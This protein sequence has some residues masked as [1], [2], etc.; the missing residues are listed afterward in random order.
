MTDSIMDPAAWVGLTS[1]AE[2]R[3]DRH[4][5]ADFDVLMGRSPGPVA[6][7]GFHWTLFGRL[8]A[9]LRR[10][11]HPR[12]MEPLPPLAF[13]RRMWAGSVIAWHLTLSAGHTA[14]R[15]TR[16]SRAAMKTGRGGPML[17]I[18]LEHDLEIEGHGLAIEERQDIAFLEGKASVPDGPAEPLPFAADW[19]APLRFDEV[20][21]FAYSALTCNMHRIHYDHPY[22]T[23]AEGFPGLV[24]HGPLLAT[25]LMHAAESHAPCAG[26]LRRFEVRARR[27]VF[28]AR[29]LMMMG[30][31]TDVPGELQ[32][33]LLDEGGRIAMTA[34]AKFDV[35]G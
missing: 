31:R 10:D 33:A 20:T 23:T 25:H 17:L 1:G 24:V 26:R 27:P 18:S 30:A 8:S 16:V 21:L 11:G 14:R 35:I 28:C 9:D 2:A 7:S 19:R 15:S 29:A 3:V 32:L 12:Q 22:A 13:E 34:L 5:M 6:A 4:R